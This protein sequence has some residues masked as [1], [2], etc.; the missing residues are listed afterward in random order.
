MVRSLVA[1]FGVVTMLAAAGSMTPAGQV[2]LGVKHAAAAQATTAVIRHAATTAGV[3]QAK[4]AAKRV[5]PAKPS[6]R[7]RPQARRAAVARRPQAA[8]SGQ[9]LNVNQLLPLLLQSQSL[10]SLLSETTPAASPFAGIMGGGPSLPDMLQQ[11]TNPAPAAEPASAPQSVQPPSPVVAAQSQPAP[12]S[13]E[14]P[15]DRH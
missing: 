2:I 4:P 9:L 12:A 11:L 7:T 1:G 6:T 3:R 14:L 10:P 15:A 5:V 13:E 8:P